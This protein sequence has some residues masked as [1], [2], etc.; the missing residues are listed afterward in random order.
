MGMVAAV[1]TGDALMVNLE[2]QIPGKLSRGERVYL[3]VFITQAATEAFDF[4][5]NQSCKVWG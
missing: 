1:K 4:K 2:G 3:E 5:R